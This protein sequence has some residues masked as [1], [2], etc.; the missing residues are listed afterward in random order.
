MAEAIDLKH[1]EHIKCR[2]KEARGTSSIQ[3]GSGMT[4]FID[5]MHLTEYCVR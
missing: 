4:E 3:L 5:T 2:E 1:N